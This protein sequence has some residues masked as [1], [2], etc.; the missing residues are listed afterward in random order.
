VILGS[1]IAWAFDRDKAS[2]H[3]FQLFA[4]PAATH[5]LIWSIVA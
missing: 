2:P 3:G 5:D 1:A 4:A